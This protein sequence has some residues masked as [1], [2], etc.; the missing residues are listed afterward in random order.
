MPIPDEAFVR[1]WINATA[2]VKDADIA[3]IASQP[4]AKGTDIDEAEFKRRNYSDEA[5]GKILGGN[6]MRVMRAVLPKS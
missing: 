6:L 2:G 5:V 1:K 4:W 3:R